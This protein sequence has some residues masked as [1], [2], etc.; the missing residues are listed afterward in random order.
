MNYLKNLFVTAIIFLLL[1]PSSYCHAADDLIWNEGEKEEIFE[2]AREQD[3]FVLILLGTYSCG[4]C[5]QLKNWLNGSLRKIMDDNYYPWF[6][7]QDSETHQSISNYTAEYDALLAVIGKSRPII[8]IINP[9]ETDDD[10]IIFWPPESRN[11]QTVRQKITPPSLLIYQ[12][13]NWHEDREDVFKLAEEQGKY[14]LK[15]VGRATS[16]NS[17]KAIKQLNVSPLREIL[18]DNYILWYSSDVSE[19]NLDGEASAGEEAI[20]TL[21]YISIIN[22][23]EPDFLL[24]EVWGYKDG[25]TLEDMLKQYTVSNE[26][27]LTNNTV[28]VSGNVLHISNQT[29]NEQI[30]IYSLDGQSIST[31]RKNDYTVTFDASNLP[32]GVFIIH[33]SA[34]WSAK[35]FKQ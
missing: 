20:K 3:R 27:I 24:E 18:E 33:S 11:E 16:P 4:W 9:E 15:L 5:N 19:A 13:L 8:L 23:E 6:V 17:V 7:F 21:P 30:R 34:G 26:K 29:L 31:L 10:F 22:P 2:T 28:F 1:F 35:V 12:D 14:I 25:E 32:K